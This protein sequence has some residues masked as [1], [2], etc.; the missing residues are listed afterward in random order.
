VSEEVMG[1]RLLAGALAL[2]AVIASAPVSVAA[3]NETTFT[4]AWVNG[5]PTLRAEGRGLKFFKQVGRDK[6]MIRVEVPGDRV[7]LDADASGAMRIGRNGRFLTLQKGE[8]F[9]ASVAKVQKFTAGSKALDAL[10][11]LAATLAGSDR[12]EAQSVLT[13][14]SFLHAVR[15]SAAPARTIAATLKSQPSARIVKA[16][17]GGRE[18]GPSAC[19]AEYSSTLHNYMVEFN[20]CASDYWWI[21]GW[22]AA[23]AAQYVLQ[24]ELAWFWVLS[25]SGGM[26]V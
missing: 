11:G 1:R 22:A 2:G 14:Y 24:A 15:G 21:P 20:S 3:G 9:T 17:A 4:L 25:C 16:M 26:P 13:S 12:M 10:E 8:P 18:E 6:V 19:W 5:E 7:Q 23:C